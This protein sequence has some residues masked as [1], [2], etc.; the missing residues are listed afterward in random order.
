MPHILLF[1]SGLF[2]CG[3]RL[4]GLQSRSGG[5]EEE[6]SLSLL[7][8]S[9]TQFLSYLAR[10]PVSTPTAFPRPWHTWRHVY[11]NPIYFWSSSSRI[12]KHFLCF[13]YICIYCMFIYSL[14]VYVSLRLPWQVFPCFFLSCKANCQGNT[15]KDGARPALFLN[16]CVVL[17]IVCFCRSVCCFCVNVY[18]TTATGWLPNCS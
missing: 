3:A 17:C 7:P 10:R 6:K 12:M 1:T 5:F 14:H 11:M 13:L 2:Y 4:Q 18:W 15:R 8:G 16:F 9:E